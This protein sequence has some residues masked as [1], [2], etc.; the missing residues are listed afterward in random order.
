MSQNLRLIILK[1]RK[2]L[3]FADRLESKQKK[4]QC[5]YSILRKMTFHGK[6]VYEICDQVTKKL[7]GTL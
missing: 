6:M 1:L 4:D 5:K 3:V 2:G 7:D